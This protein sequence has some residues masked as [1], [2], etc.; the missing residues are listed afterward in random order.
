MY[1]DTSDRNWIV[2]L[3]TQMYI[4]VKCGISG[5]SEALRD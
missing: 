2:K 3:S 1:F 5:D 4:V